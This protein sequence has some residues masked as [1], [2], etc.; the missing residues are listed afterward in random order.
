MFLQ[1]SEVPQK[2]ANTTRI[3]HRASSERSAIR[4]TL[5]RGT[6]YGGFGGIF[7]EG[8]L[9]P[10]LKTLGRKNEG[11]GG[12][13]YVWTLDLYV[14]RSKLDHLIYQDKMFQW[15]CFFRKFGFFFMETNPHQKIC[16]VSRQCRLPVRCLK[17]FTK[18]QKNATPSGKD[19]AG[20]QGFEI[21]QCQGESRF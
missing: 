2:S 21:H 16:T 5:R 15:R 10:I 4:G 7:G 9:W 13:L 12:L 8:Y 3:E 20:H 19:M 18:R 6:T 14:F 1:I 17:S 11:H